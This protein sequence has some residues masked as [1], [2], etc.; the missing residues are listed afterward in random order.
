MKTLFF[1]LS[2]L[3]SFSIFSQTNEQILKNNNWYLDHVVI[4]GNTSTPPVDQDIPY[5][6]LNFNSNDLFVSTYCNSLFG[7][8]E[9]HADFYTYITSLNQTLQVCDAPT[10]V[11]SFEYLY[12]NFFFTDQTQPFYYEIL[13]EPNGN[14]TL[15]INSASGNEAFYGNQQMSVENVSHNLFQ[16]YPNPIKTVF[17]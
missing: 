10:G 11:M 17:M 1:F 14:K 2:L 15:I 12:F 4:N 8:F 6:I 5:I 9:I 16:L 3:V 13:A 7:G